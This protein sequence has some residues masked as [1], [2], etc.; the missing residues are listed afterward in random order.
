MGAQTTDVADTRW[1]PTWKEAEG[2]ETAKERL[3][4]TG[5]QDPDLKDG[6]VDIAGC[7][8]VGASH[9][10]LIP[11][12]AVKKRRAWSSDITDAFS[13]AGGFVRGVFVQAPC[14]WDS[15]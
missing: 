14:E 13:G 8:R 11:L 12:G 3:V 6:N 2:E 9:V 4:A 5:Y 15:M 7:V 10:Q 1:V